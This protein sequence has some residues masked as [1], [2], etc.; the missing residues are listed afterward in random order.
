M[1]VALSARASSCACAAS[2]GVLLN[3]VRW[4]RVRQSEPLAQS[5]PT[6]EGAAHHFGPHLGLEWAF[7]GDGGGRGAEDCPGG[8]SGHAAEGPW[9]THTHTH[10]I[11]PFTALYGSRH[12][13]GSL[14]RVAT[15]L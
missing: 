2:I 1:R 3:L 5:G 15:V 10:T 8:V 4:Q 11:M 13:A 12:A 7:G 9:H 14:L 6:A